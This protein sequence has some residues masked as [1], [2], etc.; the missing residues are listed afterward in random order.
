MEQV[1]GLHRHFTLTC[2]PPNGAP[3]PVNVTWMYNGVPL[4]AG[5]RHHFTSNGDIYMLNITD[6]MFSDA[7]NYSCR[8]E[9]IAGFRLSTVNVTILGMLSW[10]TIRS[11][12]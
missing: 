6:V 8:A 1:A 4:A 11:H 10:Q 5:A 12:I 3:S 2:S 9:N 7:G